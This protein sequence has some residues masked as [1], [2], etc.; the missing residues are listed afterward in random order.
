MNNIDL[1]W[2][3]KAAGLKEI[4]DKT[5]VCVRIPNQEENSSTILV[6]GETAKIGEAI[7]MIYKMANAVTVGQI[8]APR[9]MHGTVK[10]EKNVHL[11]N[12]K[13][14]HPDVK[15]FFRDEHIS[16]EGPPEEVERVRTQIQST[17]DEL[18]KK[19]TTYAE[20]NI[21]PQ[22]YKQ[23]I[24]KNQ[25]R[26]LE[27]QEQS[28]CEI[29]FPFDDSRAV[30]L[31]GTKESVEKARQLLAERSTKLANE[32]TVELSIDP[33]YYPQII[34][35]KGKNLEELRSKYQNIQ[36]T[37]PEASSKSDKVT[38]HGNKD[39]VD[40]CSKA[41]LSK[42]KDLYSVEIN[43]PKRLYPLLIG[44]SG[45]N[46]Q[47]LREK[48]PDVRIDLPSLD[49]TKD[50]TSLRL[51]GKKAD[52]DKARKVLEEHVNQLN[53][54]IENSIEQHITIDPKWHSKFF[55]NKRKL[56]TD[57][58][59][60]FGEML[61]KLPERT[62]NSDQVLLRGPKETLEQ[63]RKRL[64]ELVDTWENTITKEITIPHRHHGYL[65]A[66][67]GTHIQPIQK[68]FNVQI[69]FPP[70]PT[71][72]QKDEQE[73]TVNEDENQKDIV[74]VTGRADDVEKAIVLLEKKIP[75]ETTVDIPSD[76]HGSLVG[77]GG[78]NLQ[79]LIKQYPD[80]QITFPPQNS[81][82]NTI[83][84]RGQCEQVESVRKELLESYE[85][86]QADR[87]A[88][89]FE[90]RFTIKPEYRSIVVGF[91]GKTL[92]QLRQ[93]YDVKLDVSQNST[94][95][96]AVVPQPSSSTTTSNNDED[97][98]TNEQ[99]DDQQAIPEENHSLP[100]E[101]SN[102]N[103]L[104][105]VEI[106][107]TGYEDKALACRE[108]ILRLIK[109]FESKITMEIEIDPRIHA[110]IIGSGG[111]KLQQIQKEYN[112]EIKFQTNHKNDKVHVIGLDQ[113]KI[114]ACI[115]HLLLLEEDFLQDLPYRPSSNVQNQ[116]DFTFG[117][118]LNVAQQQEVPTTSNQSKANNKSKANRQAPFQVKNAPWTNGND[119]EN[120]HQSRQ[121]N[122]H[123]NNSPKKSSAP[124]RDDL[125]EYP[126][127]SNG[128]S[129]KI[130]DD[131]SQVQTTTVNSIPVI[132]G[133]QKRK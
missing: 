43:V 123:A 11:E 44:K 69:K 101:T 66:Q 60:Q 122:G 64:E 96:S 32:S 16:L 15:I 26:L 112:V 47:R 45:A 115:D 117:Q 113:E 76:A 27:M 67:G 9:W 54:S 51:S 133:P 50:A 12:M 2:A 22:Y 55:Q 81:A 37:F 88:R 97:N 87:Q 25:A 100:T 48:T 92:G 21:D 80:V 111:S 52:V 95:S 41:L 110:R 65:L 13:K 63:V 129:S 31:M 90:V 103:Q 42:I 124:N 128:L 59:S 46:I 3:K 14:S 120:E 17:I 36:I 61:I 40:K 91:R 28:G 94:P 116:N 62:A 104:T 119:Y 109:E 108:E 132:W 20:V 8:D 57:L 29:K 114:D 73:T 56:L 83:Q 33:Q 84:L 77:K 98:S 99:Q 78:S 121:R 24:G 1:S 10:G 125:E 4:F 85:K 106:V 19:N 82:Q 107:I 5:N 53:T 38:L 30:K 49:D 89:S 126:T 58:Q 18:K 131:S 93:K 70:R 39:D 71:N 23:L 35:A 74:R 34:G 68:E 105:D 75:V 102:A 130:D 7:T 86:L 127:F 72:N 118:Q 6:Q 79:A